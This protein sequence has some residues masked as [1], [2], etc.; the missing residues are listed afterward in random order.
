MRRARAR[1]CGRSSP[2]RFPNSRGQGYTENV[3][4]ERALEMRYLGQNY[5]LELPISFEDFRDETVG[6]L[7]QSFHEAHKA[8]FGFA[9][10][11]ENI[12]IVNFSATATAR[13]EQPEQRRIERANGAPQ[14]V[15]RR[16]VGFPG[17]R[18]EVPVFRREHLAAGHEIAGPAVIEEAA[19]VTILNPGQ[20]LRVD[21]FGHLLIHAG[22]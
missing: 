6:A 20:A 21:D 2:G 18:R 15:A 7:W 19:S 8:R 3:E 13:T 12:E 17:G 22:G 9:I 5:E 14:P 10:P 16:D 11:G 4:V 1:S